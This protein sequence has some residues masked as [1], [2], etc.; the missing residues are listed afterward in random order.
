MADDPAEVPR[1]RDVPI[2]APLPLSAVRRGLE[3]AALPLG[4]AG[5]TTLGVGNRL[6]GAPA[7][8]VLLEVQGR[9]AEQLFA[10]LGQLKGGAMKFGQ[11]MSIFEAALPDEIAK[12]YRETL[13]K[14]QDAAPPM[15]PNVVHH[16]MAAQFGEEW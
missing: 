10:V 1:K 7:E 12:P 16:V 5:R 2:N 13:T 14:L 3:L 15:P 4:L 6:A 9:T 11:A 8:A